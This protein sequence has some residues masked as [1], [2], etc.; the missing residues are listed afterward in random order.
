[1][2][3]DGNGKLQFLLKIQC[4]Q[5]RVDAFNLNVEY[6]GYKP[7]KLVT[8]VL[9]VYKAQSKPVYKNTLVETNIASKKTR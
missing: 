5:W 2:D 7:V 1:M 8:R 3:V 4:H 6:I 9:S